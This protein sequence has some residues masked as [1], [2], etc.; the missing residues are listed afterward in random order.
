MNAPT[1]V[2]DFPPQSWLL[3]EVKPAEVPA[4]VRLRQWLKDGLRRHGIRA[5]RLTGERPRV[6]RQ[7]AADAACG[8]FPAEERG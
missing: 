1:P 8:S 3:V 7:D 5:I 6:E 4:A 2:D